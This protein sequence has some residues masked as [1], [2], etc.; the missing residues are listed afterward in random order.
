MQVVGDVEARARIGQLMDDIFHDVDLFT[1]AQDR[2]WV[3]VHFGSRGLG[4]ELATHFLR[5]PGA[6]RVMSRTAARRSGL[7]MLRPIAV[8]VAGEKESDPYKDQCSQTLASF[9]GLGT[10]P[11]CLSS[12]NPLASSQTLTHA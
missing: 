10:P 4:H 1:D 3:G 8:A 9:I 7:H 6:G 11:G 12:S 2:V 5:R